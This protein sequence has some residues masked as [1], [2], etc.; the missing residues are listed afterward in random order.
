MS[1]ACPW[2]WK[3]G[4]DPPH[5]LEANRHLVLAHPI[6]TPSLENP[7]PML[8]KKKEKGR[9]EREK[10]VKPPLRASAKAYLI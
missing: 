10:S 1:K 2:D 9:E 6:R 7:L 5:P 3:L 8:L 4:E